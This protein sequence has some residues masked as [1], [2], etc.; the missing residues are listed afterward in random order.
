LRVRSG[1]VFLNVPF[2]NSHEPIFIALIAGLTALRLN[3]RCVLEVPPQ[4]NRLDRLFALISGC[5]YSIHDLS[6][7][8]LSSGAGHRVPRFNMPFE[9]G[10]AVAIALAKPGK[11]SHQ[12]RILEATP[13]R[14]QK[15]L[16]DVL[17]YDPY[18]HR[19]CADGTLEALLNVFD[20][21]PRAPE[22]TGLRRLNRLLRRYRKE[23]LGRDIFQ[24]KAFSKL[25]FAA[26]VLAE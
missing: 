8:R 6:H 25:V 16:S 13:Y 14:L 2:S 17:G 24:A 23:E 3:P 10:L 26:R 1:D 9:L 18:I 21:L 20:N 11:G 19:G 12:F 4:Q 15:S 22:L 5:A 7:V